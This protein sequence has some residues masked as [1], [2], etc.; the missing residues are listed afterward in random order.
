MLVAITRSVSP[1][2]GQCEITHIPREPVSFERANTQHRQYERELV[3]LGCDIDR[4]PAEATLPDSVFIEDTAVVLDEVAVMTRPG[5]ESRRA[6]VKAVAAVLGTY[7]DLLYIEAPGT[8]DGGDVVKLGRRLYVGGG[9]RSNADGIAQLR[10]FLRPLNYEV[11]AVQAH[12]CLHLKS[13]ATSLDDDTLLLNPQWTDPAQFRDCNII[14][15][16]SAEPPAANA[17]PVNG[18]LVYPRAFARTRALLEQRNYRIRAVDL[19]ELS[20]A[21]GAVTCCSLLFER[22]Q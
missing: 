15:I 14:E 18:T 11:V 12:D 1:A 19:S 3:E 7:R 8:L 2:I 20:K 4:L 10:R 5:A 16:D 13:A 6:E 17:L 22:G 21:E 9:Q